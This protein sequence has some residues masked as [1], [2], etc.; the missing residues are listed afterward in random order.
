[1]VVLLGN[2]AVAMEKLQVIVVVGSLLV[3]STEHLNSHATVPNGEAF[4][5]EWAGVVHD[6]F[7]NVGNVNPCIA[8]ARNV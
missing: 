2:L 4:K 7:D 6:L 8:F 1:V 3:G 5:V